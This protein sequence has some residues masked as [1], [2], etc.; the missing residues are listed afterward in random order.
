MLYL[1]VSHYEKHLKLLAD[2]ILARLWQ[3]VL[4]QLKRITNNLNKQPLADI[5]A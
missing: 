5:R 4:Q 2:S 3:A 1:L